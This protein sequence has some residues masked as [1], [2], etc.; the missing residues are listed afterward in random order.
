MLSLITLLL[1]HLIS[2]WTDLILILLPCNLN[3]HNHC[4]YA[5]EGN[6]SSV[7]GRSKFRASWQGHHWLGGLSAPWSW[8]LGG[9]HMPSPALLPETWG[10][11]GFS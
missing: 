8:Q 9:A 5:T 1:T 3:A 10:I 7:V 11:L 2:I 4:N 6:S